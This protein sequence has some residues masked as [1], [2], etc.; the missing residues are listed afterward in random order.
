MHSTVIL[1]PLSEARRAELHGVGA[2]RLR[3]REP[4]APPRRR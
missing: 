1:K 4:A 2:P 3:R